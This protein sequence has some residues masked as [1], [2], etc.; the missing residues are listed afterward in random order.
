MNED[1]LFDSL[2][3]KAKA[4]L[5][6]VSVLCGLAL[7]GVVAALL[8]QLGHSGQL[9]PDRWAVL[10]DGA[11]L[12]FLL[13]GLWMTLVVGL[14]STALSVSL[15]VLLALGRLSRTRWLSLPSAAVIEFF[16]AMPLLLILFFFMFGLP[17]LGVRL[18]LFWQLVLAIV[19]HA[20]AIFA[21]IVRAG[22]LA[23]G[24]GQSE[25]GKAIG[26][27][28]WEVMAFIVLPQAARALTPALVSQTVRVIKESSLGYVVG[29]A[30][31]LNNGKVLGEFSGNFIQAYAGVGVLYIVVNIALSRLAERLADRKGSG[32]SRVQERS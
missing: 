13:Q 27:R 9:D 8:L 22:I 30:E 15:G 24:R 32:K 7:L 25:A 20:G 21:E 14:V 28:H 2:G 19:A 12:R 23:I 6:T 29:L 1:V 31:L 4:R 26:L 5:R 11:M 16:R 3:P 17:M 10:A 18:P